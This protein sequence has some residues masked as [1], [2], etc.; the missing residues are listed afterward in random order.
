M[1]DSEMLREAMAVLAVF[2]ER[3]LDPRTQEFRITR[4]AWLDIT[5]NFRERI[6]RERHLRLGM[7]AGDKAARR[8]TC[9][10]G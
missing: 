5:R 2:E 1:T 7:W 6:D 4:A 3:A 9:D 10:G 8:R